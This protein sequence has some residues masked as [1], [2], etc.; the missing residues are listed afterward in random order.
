ME[1]C[2]RD[3]TCAKLS[4]GPQLDNV[5]INKQA[6]AYRLGVRVRVLTLGREDGQSK[7]K[8]QKT[9][10]SPRR[11]QRD[12]DKQNLKSNNSGFIHNGILLSHKEE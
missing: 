2:R 9:K 8:N 5:T 3:L 10:D 6:L 11:R 1:R 4:H 12:I 7:V